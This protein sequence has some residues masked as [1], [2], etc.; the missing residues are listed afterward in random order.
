[1]TKAYIAEFVRMP[2]Q[3]GSNMGVAEN[4]PVAEQV[5]D[6]TAGVAASA[7]FNV[8][9]RYLRIT[10]DSIASFLVGEAPVAT[11]NM[12]RMTAGAVEYI[13]VPPKP[14]TYKISFI[15]NT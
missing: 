12:Q 5:V 6:Y 7:V 9:T 4:P 15:T 8:K 1:M 10:V 14:E 11:V 2:I 13:A 3:Q